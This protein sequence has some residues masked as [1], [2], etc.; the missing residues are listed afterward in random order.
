MR[1]SHRTWHAW[2]WRLIA[3]VILIA[4]YI[5]IQ[6]KQ[7]TPVENQQPGKAENATLPSS[8]RGAS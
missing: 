6:S 8:D 2:I 4:A 3:P 1:R 5:G 7:E